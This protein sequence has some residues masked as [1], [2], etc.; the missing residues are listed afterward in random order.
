MEDNR[1]NFQRDDDVLQQPS[2]QDLRGRQSVRATF[3][4]SAKAIETMSVVSVHLGIK[5]KSIFDHLIEDAQ[6]LR[7]IAR[8]LESEEFQR[9]SRIQKTFVISRKTLS[10]LEEI[11]KRF[12]APRDAL[13]EYSIQRLLP[14]IVQERARHRNRK[15]LLK[16][17][18]DYLA[19]GMK[20]LQKSKKLL[21]EDDPVSFKLESSLKTLLNAQRN[22]AEFVE[23]GEVIEDF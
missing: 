22:I 13:V 11:S 9:I 15:E 6:S 2:P 23:R 17:I 16:D 14:V 20:I 8:E 3:K 1:N 19:D 5:Q 12:K 21:G 10:C 18:N 7:H 4:L